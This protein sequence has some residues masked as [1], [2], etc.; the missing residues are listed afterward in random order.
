MP[1]L[2]VHNP[3]IN[4][5]TMEVKMMR[6]LP[7]CGKKVEI[8]KRM[9]KGKKRVQRNKLRRVDKNDE[10]EILDRR[11]VEEVVPRQFHK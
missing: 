7:L 9:E 6:C 2:A 10:E 11:K 1:W 3:E 5:G 4:W 8:A